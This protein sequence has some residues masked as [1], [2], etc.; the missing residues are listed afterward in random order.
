MISPTNGCIIVVTGLSGSGKST[1]L[2]AM[3]DLGYLAIDNLP[4]VLLPK[5]LAIRKES[6]GFI[7]LAVGMD[8]REP[9]LA[10]QFEAVFKE[11]QGMGYEL[12]LIFIEAD[13]E[14]LVKRFSETRRPHHL[15]PHGGIIEAI[16]SEI[17]YLAPLR[18]AAEDVI[19]TTS[20]KA[21]ELRKLVMSRF[22]RQG[23]EKAMAVEIL[24]FGFKNGL[25]T[26]ADLV[27][28]V[29]FLPNPF[30]LDDLRN[31]DG[32]DQPVS[33]YV[34]GNPE[35]PGFLEKFMSLLLYLL[36]LYQKE[37]KSYLTI[38]VGCT[39]GQ[40]R[41]VAVARF[42]HGALTESLGGAIHLSHR[43]LAKAKVI[44]P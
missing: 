21:S 29:R 2:K 30:Y 1:A 41:S 3:E 43:D 13:E 34:L 27:M 14:V 5:F 9:D 16:R 23:D 10:V 33:D 17:N 39:G 37:G 38:A 7:H 20:C 19:D 44:E 15:A 11:A 6:G 26:E 25:P 40:H 36:P 28:D 24:S 31:L 35:S 4:V 8:A 12:R 22:C 42:L 32:R 18:Q